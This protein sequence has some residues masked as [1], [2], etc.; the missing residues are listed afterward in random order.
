MSILNNILGVLGLLGPGGQDGSGDSQDWAAQY[1]TYGPS[2]GQRG[3]NPGLAPTP[4]FLDPSQMN[5]APASSAPAPSNDGGGVDLNTL[6]NLPANRPDAPLPQVPQ[7]PTF[8]QRHPIWNTLL[9]GQVPQNPNHPV[10][11]NFLQ[12][13]M[14][15]FDAKVNPGALQARMERQNQQ[16]QQAWEQK[17]YTAE[18]QDKIAK[19]QEDMA[20]RG[21]TPVTVQPGAAP[22]QGAVRIDTSQG[23]KFWQFPAAEATTPKDMIQ[24]PATG[25]LGQGLVK[26]GWVAKDGMV[27]VP[28]E[29]LP[30]QAENVTQQR[31]DSAQQYQAD[32]MSVAQAAG[33]KT[34]T[35][36]TSLD[37]ALANKPHDTAK[38]IEAALQGVNLSDPKAVQNALAPLAYKDM[39]DLEAHN[40]AVSKEA[41]EAQTAQQEQAHR[42]VM[43]GLAKSNQALHAQQVRLEGIRTDLEQNKY[44]DLKSAEAAHP[45]LAGV[46]EN[47]RRFAVDEAVKIGDDAAKNLQTVQTGKDIIKE[48]LAGNKAASAMI[49]TQGN[50]VLMGPQGFHRVINRPENAGNAWDQMAGKVGKGINGVG[51]TESVLKD[52]N[53]TF[54]VVGSNVQNTFNSRITN[55]NDRT[56]AKFKQTQIF[57]PTPRLTLNGR[58]FEEGDPITLKDGR[59]VKIN[60]IHPD[61]TFD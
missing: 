29:V 39:K 43:E 11:T 53:R 18:Q 13:M 56:G 16:Q 20:A 50:L 24:V 36:Q 40:L 1:G 8:D 6:L 30:Y 48:A 54:D 32:V 35:D 49:D 4:P 14:D 46:P 25:T 12:G 5:S 27:S 45:E 33:N 37:Q 51:Q 19:L 41:R 38:K 22:P 17:K 21:A 52:L 3:V 7:P 10:L 60:H 58:T 47:T 2:S 61:G 23:P 44:K 31:Q 28:K 26:Q 34:I 55:L 42:Q 57:T 59:K 15:G 9:T